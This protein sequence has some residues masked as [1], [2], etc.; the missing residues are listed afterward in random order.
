MTGNP[1]EGKPKEPFAPLFNALAVRYPE[2]RLALVFSNPFELLTAVMLSAQCTD[3]RVNRVTAELFKRCPGPADLLKLTQDQIEDLIRPTGFFH[4]K[5]KALQGACRVLMERFGGRVPERLED[6]ITLPGVGRKTAVMVLGNAFGRAQGIA[7]DTHVRR[8]A[9]RTGL[10]AAKTPE[11]IEQD[12][13]ARLPQARWT[14]AGN[15]LILHG[16]ETCG[17]RKPH[18][19]GCCLKPWCGFPDKTAG[20][21]VRR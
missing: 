17:A 7:V 20:E 13:M 18:C 1:A 3:E 14:W 5:A 6:L 2:P 21:I 19:T 15:A 9:Q 12:L 11:K 10:S 16:R 4:N 8:V